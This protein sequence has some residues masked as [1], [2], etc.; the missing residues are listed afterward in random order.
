MKSIKKNWIKHLLQ[1]GTLLTIVGFIFKLFGNDA[2]DPE[3]YCPFG[4]LQTFVTYLERGSMACSMTAT[5]IMVGVLLAIG[6]VLFSKLF[7]GYLCPLGLGTELVGR[8]RRL[9]N[10]KAIEI[11]YGSIADKALRSIKYILLFWIFYM[12]VSSSELFCKN[13]DPYY[14]FATGFK[15]E[16][17]LW[18]ASISVFIFVACSF[19]IKMFWCKYIC[20]LGGVSNIMKF[21][22]SFVIVVAAYV[23][24]TSAGVAIPWVA[25]LAALCLVG[26]IGEVF[27]GESKYFPL[28]K[29]V[30]DESTCNGCGIC[31]AKCPYGI[32]VANMKSVKHVDCTLCGECVASCH[33]K[34]LTISGSPKLRWVPGVLTVVLFFTAVKLG[35]IFEIPTIDELW[36][37]EANHTELKEVRVDGLRSVKCFGSSMS[38]AAKLQKIAGVYGVET[39]VKHSY[40]KIKYNPD[41]T[42]EDKILSQI[43]EPTKFKINTPDKDVELIRVITIRTENMHD[44]LDPNYLGLQFRNSG[45][46][47]YGLETEYDCPIIVKLYADLSEPV[48]E[49]FYKSMVEMKVLD[50][51]QHGGGSKPIEVDFKYVETESKLD[52]ITR[53]E[54]LRRQFT[55]YKQTYKKN[56]E[57]WDGTSKVITVEM[58]Y[59]SL[60]KPI[61]TRYLPYLS[62]YMSLTAGVHGFRTLVND[63]GDYVMQFDIVEQTISIEKLWEALTAPKWQVWMTAENAAVEVDP[64]ISFEGENPLYI[65]EE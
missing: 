22:I 57:A 25:L 47:Y 5:Q 53:L 7:C 35:S 43:Y 54:F 2:V 21:A 8:L 3:A 36:G 19:F 23:A 24:L 34:S 12:T 9:L 59:T 56:M 11:P 61:V 20:P 14:A 32:D 28:F 63:A 4:G 31:S 10:I 60:D 41:Q 29:I 42:S 46:K 27:F 33:K 51:P 6:V 44:K 1:W 16:L 50:M 64:S 48:D 15:G 13:F 55:P 26:F 65:I 39:Y 45:R 17:T 40:V 49:K 38:F 62:S 30:K 52:T 58:P 37:D 18:M